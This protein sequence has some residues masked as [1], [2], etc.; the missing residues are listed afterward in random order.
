MIYT[1][2]IRVHTLL[3][4]VCMYIYTQE[5]RLG[6]GTDPDPPAHHSQQERAKTRKTASSTKAADAANRRRRRRSD[7]RED[8]HEPQHKREEEEEEGEGDE[9]EEEEEEEEEGAAEE[10]DGTAERAATA[11]ATAAVTS[12]IPSSI[13]AGIRVKD[14]SIAARR[15]AP[16]WGCFYPVV[17]PP[18]MT[19]IRDN[20]Y[21]NFAH[22]PDGGGLDYEYSCRAEMAAGYVEYIYQ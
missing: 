8:E 9:E 5:T 7:G 11:T 17:L 13:L 20:I 16:G 18:K 21:P 4:Y 6:A 15:G 19:S 1:H 10:E 12:C 3:L 2:T 22:A 14:S